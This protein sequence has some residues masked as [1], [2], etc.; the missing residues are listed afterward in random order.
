MAIPRPGCDL[1]MELCQGNFEVM[2][3]FT[4]DDIIKLGRRPLLSS[5]KGQQQVFVV[6][7]QSKTVEGSGIPAYVLNRVHI[8]VHYG[9]GVSNSWTSKVA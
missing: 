5:G 7:R 6:T 9:D 3:T 2:N 8:E 1:E 4:L